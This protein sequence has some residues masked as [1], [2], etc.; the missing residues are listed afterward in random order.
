MSNSHLFTYHVTEFSL[1]GDEIMNYMNSFTLKSTENSNTYF[2]GMN[3]GSG[4]VGKYDDIINEKKL[5]RLYIIKGA[6]GTGKSTLMHRCA[7]KAE[8]WG[9][10]VEYYLCSSDPDS[11]D[12]VVIDGKIAIVDGTSPHN[13]DMRYPGAVSEIVNVAGFLDD[14]IIASSKDEIISLSEK[15]KTAFADAYSSLSHV[16]SLALDRYN[17]SIRAV[18]LD[19]LER[20]VCRLVSG[21]KKNKGTGTRRE[22]VL[23]AVGMKGCCSLDTFAKRAESVINVSDVY[24]SA[25]HYM[26]VLAAKLEREGFDIIV[27]PDPICPSLICDIFIPETSILITTDIYPDCSKRINMTRFSLAPSLSEIRGIMRLSHK[28]SEALLS[29][30]CEKLKLGGKAHFGL[31]KLYSSAMDFD[32]LSKYTEKL[33]RSIEKRLKD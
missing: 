9:C 4:F 10:N 26:D 17:L 15:K 28:C 33:L 8:S 20:N 31:E 6:A 5:T 2:V 29:E 22:A 16:S 1:I 23:K 12:C 11:L 27:S 24:A 7:E 18:D 14:S 32:A 25:Y 13:L 30:A 19:K 3:T 21:F